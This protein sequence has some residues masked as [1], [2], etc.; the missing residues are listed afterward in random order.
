MHFSRVNSVLTWDLSSFCF[1]KPQLQNQNQFE[2]K[3]KTRHRPR[4]GQMSQKVWGSNPARLVKPPFGSYLRKMSPLTRWSTQVPPKFAQKLLKQRE[5]HNK[6]TASKR[7]YNSQCSRGFIPKNE[8]V[9]KYPCWEAPERK[10]PSCVGCSPLKFPKCL[11]LFAWNQGLNLC[12]GLVGW[13]K[14][15]LMVS[16]CFY[17]RICAKESECSFW[18][19]LQM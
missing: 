19:H 11:C 10:L 12:G 16:I 14:I 1:A 8:Q 13:C 17:L 7:N 5:N 9:C 6:I 2:D 18:V 3:Y 4:P 15:K